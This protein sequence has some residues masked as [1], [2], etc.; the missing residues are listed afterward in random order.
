MNASEL[1]EKLSL[2]TAAAHLPALVQQAAASGQAPQAFLE[3]LLTPEVDERHQRSVRLAL[4]FAGF[5]VQKRLSEF[6]FSFQPGVPKAL[7]EEL[8]RGEFLKEGRNIILLG[9]PGVGKTHLAIGLGVMACEL[10]HRACFLTL[11]QL[12][13]R[14]KKAQARDQLQREM[15][16]LCRPKLLI[17]DEV[18]Y[19]PLERP[20]ASL[21]FQLIAQRY[22]R[23]N[24]LVITS[25]KSFGQWGEVFAGDAVM[26][27]AALDRL[28]HKATVIS[29]QGESYRL[30]GAK[31]N[32][33]PT[34]A[35]T[36][37]GSDR[38]N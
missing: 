7:I 35:T 27:T 4:K 15:H 23:G 22:Q 17:V 3:A 14:F 29:I 6:Q 31:A 37:G 34:L 13:H 2:T 19:T 9:P 32:L 1:L 25:N 20:E 12:C 10:N 36:K 8:G 24:S 28:L 33:E 30:K 26:A 38:V 21:L 16:N 18:G 5:P 11:P